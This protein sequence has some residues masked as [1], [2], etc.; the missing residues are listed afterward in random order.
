[1]D[2]GINGN[3]MG[4]PLTQQAMRWSTPKSG[5]G[6]KGVRSTEGA[7]KEY[8]RKGSGADLPTLTS[9]WPTPA[10]RDYRT[11]NSASYQERSGTT[12][13]EQLVN[14]VAH[15]WPTPTVQDGDSSGGWGCIAR[16]N[17]SHSLTTATSLHQGLP[18]PDGPP[19]STPTRGSRPP[20]TLRLNPYFVEWLMGWPAGWTV[21]VVRSA[22]SAQATA[23]WHSA[24][25]QRLLCF[26]GEP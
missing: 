22:S 1:M 16:G 26:F 17:R 2:A 15:N 10:S 11:P 25:Q 23:W 4:M 6:D 7:Q 5:D 24:L 8:A 3:G 13:G 19:S 14:F 9:A 20:L 18:M 12:K 21:A